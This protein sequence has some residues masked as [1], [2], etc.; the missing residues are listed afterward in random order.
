V[1][2]RHP[3]ETLTVTDAVFKDGAWIPTAGTRICWLRTWTAEQAER[4][5]QILEREGFSRPWNPEDEALQA[6]HQRAIAEVFGPAGVPVQPLGLGACTLEVTEIV[7]L[8]T[9]LDS[10]RRRIP[11]P[12][13]LRLFNSPLDVVE[14]PDGKNRVPEP[15]W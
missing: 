8:N 12:P 13:G 9:P 6:A 11:F 15:R 7:S 10:M 14:D 4:L 1:L 5:A 3:T 2:L